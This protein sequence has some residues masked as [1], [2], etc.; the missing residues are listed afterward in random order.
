MDRLNFSILESGFLP[1]K[2][3]TL[4]SNEFDDV[5]HIAKNLPKILANNQIE[6]EVLNLETEKDIS[7]LSIDELE[8]AMLLYSYIGHGYI[9]G[10]TNIEKVIPKNISKTW[11][12]ISQKLDRPPI[13]SYASYA[14]NNWK[15]QDVNK[16]FDL[17]NIRI[18]QNFLGGIDEDWFIM[19]HIAIEHEAKEILNNLKTY[20]IDKNEDQSYLENAL[21]SIKKINQIMNRM[22][23]KCDP[24][25]YYN[26]VRPYIFGWKNN[27][28]TPNGV[29]YEGVEEYGGNPQLFRGETGAQS[30]IVP[31]LDALLGVTHSNDPLKEYL[32]EMRLYMPKEHR[33][34]LN[35][36]D[37]WSKNNRSKSIR[38]DSSVVLSD[39]I[40]KEVHAFRNKHLEYARIYIHEQSLSNQNNSN[41]VGTGGTPFM[42]YLDKHLQETVPSND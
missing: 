12:K 11:Y 9:W 22:P 7:N 17:E 34:M 4:L 28:A 1:N 19:I 32:D 30:S 33:N 29:I 24:F 16:P 8:R 31:A 42:K 27:P 20:Y 18:L 6:D 13:L 39:E 35:D 10:G 15:L 37:Q 21:E 36:L 23:E 38:E 40:I 26:R 2:I 5:E 14:L 25:I 3:S 41:V